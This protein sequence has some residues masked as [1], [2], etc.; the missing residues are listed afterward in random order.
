MTHIY[1]LKNKII[2]ALASLGLILCSYMF[3][4]YKL[5]NLSDECT[6]KLSGIL[7]NS[8]DLVKRKNEEKYICYSLKN[9]QK[10]YWGDSVFTGS[11]STGIIRLE[12]SNSDIILTKNKNIKGFFRSLMDMLISHAVA[13]D[14]L[15]EKNKNERKL[16]W[17]LVDGPLAI[18]Y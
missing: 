11:Q 8:S 13:E 3:Y 17:Q 6:G 9:K 15:I 5:V 14:E 7:F 16:K 4:S 18:K 1:D 10:T 2:L 12:D